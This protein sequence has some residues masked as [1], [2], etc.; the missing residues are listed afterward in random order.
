[1]KMMFIL[2]S[3]LFA[4]SNN[5]APDFKHETDSLFSLIELKPD[6]VIMVKI[7]ETINQN[8]FNE[9]LHVYDQIQR[10]LPIAEELK[11]QKYAARLYLLAGISYDLTGLYDSAFVQ[12]DHGLAIAEKHGLQGLMGEL[13]NNYSITLVVPG[14]LDESIGYALKAKEIFEKIG[15]S[16]QLARIYNNLG[17][18]YAEIRLAE[19]ALEH[20]LKAASINNLRND[21]TRLAYNYGNIGLLYHNLQKPEMALE[22]FFKSINLLDTIA[23]RY[24]YSIAMNNLALAYTGFGDYQTALSYQDRALQIAHEVNDELG[25]L[26]ALMGLAKIYTGLKQPDKALGFYNQSE[27][28]ALSLGARSNLMKIFEAKAQIYAELNDFQKA[29]DFNQKFIV[30]RDSILTYERD[31]ALEVLQKFEDAKRE[32]EIQLLT[33]DGE[34]Q[35]L[36][37]RRQKIIRNYV[38]VVGFLILLLAIGL[39]SRYRYVRKTRNELA[40]K[41][42]IINY[43]KSRSDE[44]LLNI[45]PAETAEELK[46]KGSSEARHFEMVTVMFTDFIGFTQRAEVLSAQELVS[47]ID[48]CFKAFDQIIAKYDIEKIK[49]IGDS[50]MCA[51]GL[52]VSNDTNPVDVVMAALEIQQFMENLKLQKTVENKPYFELRIGIHTGPVVAGIVGFKKFQYDIWGDTVNI[53]SR[54]ESSGEAA[55]INISESTFE[56]IKH[57]FNCL[58]RGKIVARNKGTLDMYFVEGLKTDPGKE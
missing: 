57:R 14:R 58:H 27:S 52:P 12:Y 11:D 56:K 40:R 37:I 21:S 23:N 42:V 17:S 24:H 41:N 6:T 51:G 35:K 33:K 18:R 2:I 49:T 25:I 50:Y 30:I 48:H 4:G 46:N 10:A 15:D 32:H 22:Y 8:I 19:L 54:M 20:Y 7:I 1:M 47:E 28:I 13:Y 55:N 5:A 16:A 38:S 44:L 26:T 9:P 34:I 43:E 45:L 3:L 36:M 39:F 29:F 31:K 53:A